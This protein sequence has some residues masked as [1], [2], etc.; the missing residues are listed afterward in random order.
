MDQFSLPLAERADGDG[1][2]LSPATRA[3]RR[4]RARDVLDA[5]GGAG[6]ALH[7]M[8]GDDLLH[9]ADDVVA[10]VRGT[11]AYMPPQ[12]RLAGA[13]L[14]CRCTSQQAGHVFIRALTAF[15]QL[16]AVLAPHLDVL[17]AQLDAADGAQAP[18][19]ATVRDCYGQTHRVRQDRLDDPRVRLLRRYR[20]DGTPMPGDASHLHRDNIDPDGSKASKNWHAMPYIAAKGDRPFASK[21]SATVA[22]RRLG[23]DPADYEMR[24]VD[25]GVI[26]VLVG[27]AATA[28]AA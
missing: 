22:V 1:A 23:Q 18:Q 12:E 26:A 7:A 6:T 8:H 20:K 15:P 19:L 2:V 10:L 25:G 5:G 17:R 11:L 4:Q 24:A 3:A 27:A 16:G 9:Q 13:A 28:G 14:L 21:R